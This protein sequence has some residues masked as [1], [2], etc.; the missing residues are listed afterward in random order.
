MTRP[1]EPERPPA[2]AAALRGQIDRGE[3]G[4]K[5]A[6]PD[7]AAA[8]LGTDAEAG[9]TPPSRAELALDAQRQAVGMRHWSDDG[10]TSRMVLIGGWLVLMVMVLGFIM[11]STGPRM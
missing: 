9:G 10:P 11:L 6:F 5:V 4:D 7:P 1:H 3:T 8:P 2:T